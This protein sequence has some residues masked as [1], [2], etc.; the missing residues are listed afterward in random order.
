MLIKTTEVMKDQGQGPKRHRSHEN[1]V[2]PLI[3]VDLSL[4]LA[5]GNIHCV[6]LL[7]AP[8]KKNS[9]P[10]RDRTAST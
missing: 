8:N 4:I 9:H 10:D 7:E 5:F 6:I 1:N 2:P 3:A